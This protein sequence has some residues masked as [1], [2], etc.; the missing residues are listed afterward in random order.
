MAATYKPISVFDYAKLSVKNMPIDTIQ[1]RLVDDVSKMIWNYAPWRWTIGTLDP[2]TITANQTDFTVVNPQT[3][4][5]YITKAYLSNGQQN[6]DLLPT[7]VLPASP[8]IVGPAK[9]ISYI[10]GS[11]PKFRLYP[12]Y[13]AFP[14]GEA[15]TLRTWY[16]KI[17]PVITKTNLNTPGALIMDDEYFWVFLEGCMYK[18]YY[19]ADDARAGNASVD[20]KGNI[21]YTG[22]RAIFEAALLAMKNSEPMLDLNIL[23]QV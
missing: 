12:G 1:T 9:N 13:G 3:D 6:V 11:P 21:T 8:T 4:L 23:G 18:A 16:K 15:W 7:S 10:P 2:V 19:Y 22:Q 5:L 14:A 17:S 20:N